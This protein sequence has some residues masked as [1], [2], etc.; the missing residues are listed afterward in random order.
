MGA[1]G[2]SQ[3]ARPLPKRQAIWCSLNTWVVAITPCNRKC[4]LNGIV[5]TSRHRRRRHRHLGGGIITTTTLIMAVIELGFH[6]DS[7]YLFVS[8]PQYR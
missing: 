2:Q 8:L 4:H 6:A 5:G 1:M 3:W 7:A